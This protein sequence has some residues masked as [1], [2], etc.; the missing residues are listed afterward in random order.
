MILIRGI[1]GE[2][3]ARRI[4][5]G[6]VDCRDILSALLDPPVTG[7]EYSDYCE[8]NLVRALSY[9]WKKDS[10]DLRHPDFLH[11]LLIDFYIPHIYLTYFHVLN[12]HSLEWLDKFDDDYQFIAMNVKI[13][14]LTGTAIGNEFF[15]AKMSY[16]DSI[17]ELEQDGFRGFQAA[18]MCS[19]ENLFKNKEDMMT[20]LQI[21]NT[22]FFA[23]LC[24]EQDQKFTDIENEFR[25][26]AYD[27]P[28]IKGKI[29]RQE[30]REATLTGKTGIK[31]SGVLQ[32]GED[33]VFKSNMKVLKNPEKS[34]YDILV[35]EQGMVTLDSRFKPID[36]GVISD[37]YGYL[38]NKQNCAAFINKM[39]ACKPQD[40]YVD[41]TI[42]KEY[43]ISDIPDAV[44]APGHLGVDY[45]R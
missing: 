18:C 13:D 40:I 15:G 4:E 3:Y 14:R 44:F 37:D 33:T 19:I 17:C 39:L 28:R 25:I 27:C 31:Y 45:S 9:F 36:I 41:R 42:R 2:S 24:R 26:I 23:L 32:A 34:L 22:L 6:I 38:G 5:K 30:S 8:K 20:S 21:Y 16:V 1:K 11:S 29:A 35:E 7:Y 12:E 10:V 43:K